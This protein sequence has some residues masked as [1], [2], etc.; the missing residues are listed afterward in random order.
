MA[1]TSSAHLARLLALVPYLLRHPGIPLAEAARTFGVSQAELRKD[2][3][4]IYMCGLPGYYPDDLIEVDIGPSGRITVSNADVIARPLRLTRDEALPLIVALRMFADL[5]GVIDRHAVD[6]ALAKLEDALQDASFVDA[7]PVAVDVDPHGPVATAV[8]E[9]LE[10]KRRL[11]LRYYVPSR[12]EVTERDVDPLRLEVVDGRSYLEGWCR[13]AEAVR[14][15]RLDRILEARVLDAPCEPPPE[16]APRDLDAGIFQPGPG[17]IAV[18]LRLERPAHWVAEYYPCEEIE[19]SDD[20]ALTVV[21][22]TPDTRWVRRLL[23]RLGEAARVL[24]PPELAAE[25]R[26]EAETALRSYQELGLDD[27]DARPVAPN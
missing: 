11:R 27:F 17:Q 2:L 18:T 10:T 19:T 12:D 16:A 4:L 21:L 13:R 24:D 26:T 5:P 25:M 1:A 22:R 6:S 3:N 14:L 15:F 9:A 20:G 23:L 8:R 7:Q